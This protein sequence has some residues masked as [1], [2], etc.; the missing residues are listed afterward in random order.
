MF[1]W[2]AA[3]KSIGQ[4]SQK[5][6]MC[7]NKNCFIVTR[8]PNCR[9]FWNNHPKGTKHMQLLQDASLIG[10]CK[11]FSYSSRELHWVVQ[12]D[13]LACSPEQSDGIGTDSIRKG[14]PRCRIW[15]SVTPESCCHSTS[16]FCKVLKYMY[17]SKHISVC[18]SHSAVCALLNLHSV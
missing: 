16:Q 5:S 11:N 10:L 1:S 14:F 7:A 6:G 8:A 12:E 2:T 4:S 13:F 17:T 3:V 9:R 18:A 15:L